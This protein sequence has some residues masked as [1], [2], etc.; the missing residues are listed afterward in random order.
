MSLEIET[1]Y[2][3]I[4]TTSQHPDF[5]RTKHSSVWFLGRLPKVR[6]PVLS[7]T[8]EKIF[9]EFRHI[10]DLSYEDISSNDFTKAWRTCAM[11]VMEGRSMNA[12]RL[13]GNAR[14][15]LPPQR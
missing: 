11:A 1:S 4:G 7:V 2:R 9:G 12:A 8:G 3:L 14:S 15:K 5:E 13:A 10:I 6:A